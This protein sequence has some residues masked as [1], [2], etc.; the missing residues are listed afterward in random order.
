MLHDNITIVQD[1]RLNIEWKLGVSLIDYKEEPEDM[2]SFDGMEE[3]EEEDEEMVQEIERA[4][5]DDV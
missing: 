4:S 2:I 3:Q 1:Q 5:D